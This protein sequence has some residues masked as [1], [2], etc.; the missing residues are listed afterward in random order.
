MKII[1]GNDHRGT[2]FALALVEHL[3]SRGHE[4]EHLGARTEDSCDYPDIAAELGRRVAEA[5]GGSGADESG[6]FGIGLC[7]SGVGI[8]LALNKVKGIR[9]TP[10]WND[11]LAEYVK[12]HNN[13]NV[14]CF[15]GMFTS[16][17]DAAAILEAW[18]SAE[19]EGG[20]HSRR[21]GKIKDYASV[22]KKIHEHGAAA[23]GTFIFG[24]DTDTLD[25]FD[26][27][28]EALKKWEVDAIE[29][30][31]LCPF[32]GTPLFNKF[33]KENRILTRDWSKYDQWNIVFKPKNMTPEELWEKSRWLA[34][35]YYSF[36]N[37]L[38]KIIGSIKLGFSP[39]KYVMPQILLAK[40]FYS[41]TF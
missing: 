23:I 33:E 4:V 34:K 27:T 25:V 14:L 5:T 8:C 31:I 13:A 11:H 22:V 9:A 29:V 19:F 36:P 2:K 41:K 17:E 39:F 40:R 12:R 6:V 10:V 15:S 30:N 37:F 18:L 16:P 24:L 1:I 3:A 35:E 32:P 28:N 20:R 21:V 38:R 26:K 7:G